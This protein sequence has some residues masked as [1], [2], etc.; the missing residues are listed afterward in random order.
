LERKLTISQAY[1]DAVKQ[2]HDQCR[3]D[4]SHVETNSDTV[5][6]VSSASYAQVGTVTESAFLL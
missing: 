4:G 1:T 6:A 2:A 5:S 3:Q